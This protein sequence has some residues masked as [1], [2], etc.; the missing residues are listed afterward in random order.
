MARDADGRS[1]QLFASELLSMS[2]AGTSVVVLAACRTGV[3]PIR[4]GE[5]PVSLAR[6]F[7]ARGVP[8]VVATLWDI[9]DQAS[10]ALFRSFYASL[11]ADAEPAD[12][13]R[14]AQLAMLHDSDPRHQKPSAWAGFIDLGGV[15]HIS[16]ERRASSNSNGGQ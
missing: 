5:G 1:G 12:A 3:G 15:M 13:L 7:L 4:R 11:R 16:D 14:A 6:P 9:D 10:A 2:L 8:S